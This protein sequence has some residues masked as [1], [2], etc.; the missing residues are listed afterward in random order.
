MQKTPLATP[1]LGRS[2]LASLLSVI[3]LGAGLAACSGGDFGRVRQDAR[4]DDMHR[5]MGA[6][7]TGSIGGR[8]SRFQLTDNERQLRDLAYPLVEPPHSRPAWKSVFG[9]Y[10]PLA[11]PWRQ[12]PAFDRSAYGRLLLDEPH[13]SHASR[14]A[15]LIDDVRDDLTRF[16]PF[17]NTARQ[18]FDLDSKRNASLRL[19]SDLSPRERADAVARME[20]NALI[21]QWVQ[22]CLEQRIAS[23]RWALEHLVI[24]APD[25]VAADADRLIGHLATLTANPPV[26]S[27]PVVGRALRTRG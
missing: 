15:Q 10:D 14:Y 23:Y 3:L 8:P 13:R 21:V 9:N 26:A 2:R 20:E 18:V 6:E 1:G 5:W 7:A 11:A 17:F 27:A 25:G 4:N 12:R 16:D 19:V 22:Q 24:H